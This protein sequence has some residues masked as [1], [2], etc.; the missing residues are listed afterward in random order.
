VAGALTLPRRLPWQESARGAAWALI[1]RGIHAILLHG[2]RG[3]GKKSLAFELA[4]AALCEQA[5]DAGRACGA[6]P[7]CL[8]MEAG[9]HPDFRFV[10][11]EALKSL[12]PGSDPKDDSEEDLVGEPEDAEKSGRASREIR[13]EQIRALMNFANLGTHRG[14]RH[15]VLLAPGES[16]NAPAA[17]ALLKLLEE[18]PG[19]ALFLLCTDAIDELP[20]TILSRCV[21]VRVEGPTTAAAIEW[22]TA[23]GCTDPKGALAEAGGAPLAALGLAASAEEERDR[24]LLRELLEDPDSGDPAEIARRIPRDVSAGVAIAEMQRWCWDLI[25][26]RMAGVVR[27]HPGRTAVIGRIAERSSDARLWEW[28]RSI[29][30]RQ[31]TRE[32]PLNP[33]LVVESLLLQYRACIKSGN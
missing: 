17:N 8:L 18:P 10:L 31:A 33:R 23:Q 26:Y 16:L 30:M 1:S 21:L 32:H 29:G 22:L 19:E 28:S 4:M 9:S 15:V 27:Y 13:I 12:K 24:A 11:P 25:A 2:S 6:C 7:G 5:A 14:G 20:P 3:I